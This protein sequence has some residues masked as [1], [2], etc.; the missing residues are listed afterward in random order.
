MPFWLDKPSIL[1]R[2]HGALLL[3]TAQV[4]ESYPT[5]VSAARCG[6]AKQSILGHLP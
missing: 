5:V 2:P 4:S 3:W 1:P 6:T